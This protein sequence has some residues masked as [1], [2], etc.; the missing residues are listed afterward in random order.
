MRMFKF[1]I[2]V[3]VLFWAFAIEATC[4]TANAQDSAAT[5]TTAEHTWIIAPPPTFELARPTLMHYDQSTIPNARFY[6]LNAGD[7]APVAGILLNSEA[8][9]WLI[10]QYEYIQRYWI[11]EMNRR[12]ELTLNWGTAE[13]A[14]IR[15][16]SETE[17]NALNI[18]IHSLEQQNQLLTETTQRLI[19]EKRRQ[20]FLYR[21]LFSSSAIAIVA[22]TTT[23][24]I[25]LVK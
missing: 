25:I 17:T 19:R 7:R 5:P 10:A 13:A 9:A 14:G 8:N 24:A 1:A 15:V 21:F 18:R 4:S 22:A 20:R 16:R 23:T 11:T 6:T 2:L 3:L 12:V